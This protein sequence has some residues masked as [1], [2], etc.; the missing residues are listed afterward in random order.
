MSLATVV[1]VDALWQTIWTSAVAA[2]GATVVF[3]LAVLGSSRSLEMRRAERHGLGAVYAV[4]ALLGAAATIAAIVYAIA[5][6]TTK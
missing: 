3:S 1:D 2:I 5:L 6:I 4:V